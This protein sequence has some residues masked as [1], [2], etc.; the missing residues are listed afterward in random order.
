MEGGLP[1][2]TTHQSLPRCGTH[3]ST[4][5]TR[6]RRAGVGRGRCDIRWCDGDHAV[7]SGTVELHGGYDAGWSGLELSVFVGYRAPHF[8]LRAMR[9]DTRARNQRRLYLRFGRVWFFL[10]RFHLRRVRLELVRPPSLHTLTA[11]F[12]TTHPFTRRRRYQAGSD[13]TAIWASTDSHRAPRSPSRVRPAR[14]RRARSPRR[15]R[16]TPRVLLVGRTESRQW[17]QGGCISLWCWT[18]LLMA[19]AP[20]S[21]ELRGSERWRGI[22][23]GMW[24]IW[25]AQRDANRLVEAG[26]L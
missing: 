5:A 12:N 23:S 26:R 1:S 16:M 14:P 18:T 17:A 3:R 11:A 9:C 4:P 20:R 7:G 15:A 24:G 13:G 21:A 19:M 25:S 6:H 8:L 22:V 10:F 2:L